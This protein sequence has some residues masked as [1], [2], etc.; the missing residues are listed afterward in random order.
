M[1]YTREVQTLIQR[2]S[3]TVNN[4]ADAK[5][6]LL[7]VLSEL[8]DANETITAYYDS[9]SARLTGDEN[10]LESVLSEL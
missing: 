7:D 6:A 3:E 8:K 1:S 10:L 9:I 4:Y 5:T 2:A